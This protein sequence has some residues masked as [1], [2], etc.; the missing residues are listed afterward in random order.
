M[1]PGNEGQLSDVDLER[2]PKTSRAIMELKRQ[3]LHLGDRASGDRNLVPF[4]PPRVEDLKLHRSAALGDELA[5]NIHIFPSH[6]LGGEA[7]VEFSAYLSSIQACCPSDC[8]HC[9]LNCV[10]NKSGDTLR[11]DLGNRVAPECNHRRA[12]RHGFDHNQPERLRPVDRKQQGGGPTKEAFFVAFTDLSDERDVRM[13]GLDHWADFGVPIGLIGA[14]YLCC[15]L[16]RHP[17]PRC[18]LDGEIGPFLRRDTTKEGEVTTSTRLE[19]KEVARK[20]M[21]DS[22]EPVH[23]VQI[24]L[25]IV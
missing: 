18:D 20:T 13:V 15:N 22:A 6:P 12:T 5:I 14:I 9:F 21:V 1:P 23:V 7:A 16:Q 3:K 8:R 10:D 2:K 19:R 25:L 11:H 24:P 17:A 4:L